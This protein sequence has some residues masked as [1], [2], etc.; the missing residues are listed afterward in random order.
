MADTGYIFQGQ[1]IGTDGVLRDGQDIPEILYSIQKKFFGAANVVIDTSYLSVEFGGD[2]QNSQPNAFIRT[3]QT[4]LYSQKVPLQNPIG[5]IFEDGPIQGYRLPNPEHIQE[6]QWSNYN[7]Y[8]YG[9]Y[10]INDNNSKKYISC[11]YPYIAYYKDLLLTAIYPGQS[12]NY[13]GLDTTYTHP[14][15]Q[16]AIS[17][18]YDITYTPILLGINKYSGGSFQITQDNGSWILDTDAGVLTFYDV[19]DPSTSLTQV[20]RTNAPRKC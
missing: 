10:M 20:S 13:E 11:N 14:L 15:L 1:N 18:S 16:G 7:Y 4:S 17:G 12:A 5:L 2:I 6:V 3:H 19:N 9:I 8:C